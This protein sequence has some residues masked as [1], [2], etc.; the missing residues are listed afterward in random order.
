MN[1]IEELTVLK[2]E[3]V[4][5]MDNIH[6]TK[7]ARPPIPKISTPLLPLSGG[8]PPASPTV[9]E[10]EIIVNRSK[11]A[12][13][14]LRLLNHCRFCQGSCQEKECIDTFRLMKHVALCDSQ[15]H[16]LVQGCQTTKKLLQ[17]VAECSARSKA[18]G[19]D[20][21]NNACLVCT[22][23]A[24]SELC[25]SYSSPPSSSKV[26]PRTSMSLM[27]DIGRNNND[28][29]DDGD[30]E[31]PIKTHIPSFCR[32][33]SVSPTLDVDDSPTTT[34]KRRLSE[35]MSSSDSNFDTSMAHTTSQHPLS[36]ALSDA[37]HTV[38]NAP[39][40]LEQPVIKSPRLESSN[41][42]TVFSLGNSGYDGS[43]SD[44]RRGVR[45]NP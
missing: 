35:S 8:V 5:I 31:L 6:G 10:M 1:S 15:S 13:S 43:E 28:D 12:A 2:I 32:P 17:H 44:T 40:I 38:T 36:T 16:C 37:I 14:Y 7:G 9:N 45:V 25:F 27:N 30:D 33:R 29:V 41:T 3:V 4:G 18:P 22:L 42:T 34:T 21:Q 26:S 19:M 23:A 20:G 39:Q 11:K 24:S